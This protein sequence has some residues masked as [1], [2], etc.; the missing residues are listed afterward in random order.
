MGHNLFSDTPAVTLQPTDLVNTN[1]LLAP[2][3]DNGG[4]TDTQALLNGSPAIN[5]GIGIMG[6]ASD[7]RGDPRPTSGTTDIGDIPG[8]NVIG[9]RGFESLPVTVLLNLRRSVVLPQFVYWPKSSS[10]SGAELRRIA[11]QLLVHR[12]SINFEDGVREETL[13]SLSVE[14]GKTNG[15]KPNIT[16]LKGT[17]G[18]A[19]TADY[20][21]A[22]P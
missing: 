15:S 4:P 18:S 11:P 14:N 10:A 21:A 17:D 19:A 8:S 16:D 2:L 22:T 13:V 1:P 12:I 7:Q 6:I 9:G 5:A 3:G 20:S